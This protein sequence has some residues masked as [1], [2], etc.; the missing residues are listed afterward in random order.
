MMFVDDESNSGVYKF[1]DVEIQLINSP[2]SFKWKPLTI[3]LTSHMF[4]VPFSPE[5]S[6]APEQHSNTGL[7][8]VVSIQL[9]GSSRTPSVV[10]MMAECEPWL[11]SPC[12]LL[13]VCIGCI[14][15]ICIEVLSHSLV[16]GFDELMS[17]NL[18]VCLTMIWEVERLDDRSWDQ[19]NLRVA[20]YRIPQ[21]KMLRLTERWQ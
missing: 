20:Q 8:N 18:L 7:R 13:Y 4:R 9:H 21:L 2:L 1:S 19:M 5:E 11:S 15:S 10:N 6:R 14:L 3:A 12:P 16:A 17:C